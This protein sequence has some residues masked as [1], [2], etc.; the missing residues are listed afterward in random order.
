M[1]QSWVG[2][3]PHERAS[4]PHRTPPQL[5]SRFVVFRPQFTRRPAHYSSP[6]SDAAGLYINYLIPLFTSRASVLPA[7]FHVCPLPREGF[8]G[9]VTW[10]PARHS[11]VFTFSALLLLVIIGQ[12][13]NGPTQLELGFLYSPLKSSPSP[14]LLAYRTRKY[15]LRLHQPVTPFW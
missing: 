12:K 6:E 1:R 10:Y 11:L 13:S 14:S 15:V 3:G 7:H 9:T 2:R 8:P 4:P 5:V